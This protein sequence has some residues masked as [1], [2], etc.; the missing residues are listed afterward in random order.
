MNFWIL[1]LEAFVILSLVFAGFWVYAKKIN[2]Y[3]IVDIIW[4]YAFIFILG[5]YVITSKEVIL[6]QVLLLVMVGAWSLR[7]GTF[8]LR[9]IYS[10]HPE[11]DRRYLTLRKKY[12][13]KVALQFFWFFQY[14]AWSVVIL[15]LL[16]L[17]VSLNTTSE[18]SNLEIFGFALWVFAFCGEAVADAQKSAFRKESKNQD[19]ICN[20]GLWRYSRH[21]NYFFESLIWFSYFIFALGTSGTWYTIYS[22]LLILFLLLKVTGIPMAEAQSL[23]SR[24]EAFR[25]Y[26][27]E[28]SIFIPWWPRLK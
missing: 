21:P 22:P 20:I 3:S 26:Q 8:L 18:L 7:L 27:S 5:F 15:S 2:N 11:E 6:R 13:P 25:K 19:K 16:F 9:R 14:Q 1:V 28:T 23:K 12:A 4:S 24:G 17:E 10:H